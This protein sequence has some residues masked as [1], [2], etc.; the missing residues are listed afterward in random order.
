VKG[1]AEQVINEIDYQLNPPN[2]FKFSGGHPLHTINAAFPPIKSQSIQSAPTVAK[3]LL[4][5]EA[6]AVDMA[7]LGLPPPMYHK[8]LGGELSAK[9]YAEQGKEAYSKMPQ[10][11]RDAVRSYTGF[12]YKAINNS[13]WSG[14]PTGEAIA[15]ATA[16]K[17]L[18]HDL[19][20]GTL[21]S[22][23]IEVDQSDLRQLVGSVG[24]VLQEERIIS[25]SIKPD[26]WTGNVHLKLTVGP[27]VRGLYVGVGSKPDG[28]AISMNKTEEE[29]ILPPNTRILVTK[30]R[31]NDKL[32][33]V[34]GY[35]GGSMDAV[36]EA[37]ILPTT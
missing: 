30:V 10:I 14:N 31:T 17:T 3:F 32:P 7:N 27:G 9:T 8:N 11:Q 21:L 26:V 28:D 15:A 6:G 25:T 24:K 23:K 37:I 12:G 2:V 1:Y 19:A 18:S 16:I 4:V 5:G 22:R 36:I 13:L 34:E 33:D 29:I 20:P 35:G